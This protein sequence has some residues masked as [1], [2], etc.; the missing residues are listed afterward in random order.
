[1]ADIKPF[2]A[3]GI[4]LADLSVVADAVFMPS[5]DAAGNGQPKYPG[6]IVDATGRI[7][8]SQNVR[9]KPLPLVSVE[10]LSSEPVEYLEEQN[11]RYSQQLR[12]IARLR[13][14]RD[15]FVAELG[16]ELR[17]LGVHA[18]TRVA[19]VTPALDDV[20]H[21]GWLSARR[22]DMDQFT[23]CCGSWGAARFSARDQAK[24]FWQLR[25]L[26]PERAP[27]R[28]PRPARP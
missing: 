2:K 26:T 8:L 23:I 5:G 17:E 9:E 18:H 27:A 19:Q 21:A 12:R 3:M 13:R 20:V 10:T 14:Q 11:G 4:E 6:G 1:M 16:E 7:V 28:R 15:R 25:E 22:A 24:F